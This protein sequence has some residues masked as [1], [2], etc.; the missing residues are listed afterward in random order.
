MTK[1]F[2]KHVVRIAVALVMFF[3]VMMLPIDRWFEAPTNVYVEFAL[4]L[5]PYLVAGYDVLIAAFKN[6]LKG[7]ALDEDFLMTV[8]TIGAFAMVFF[9]DSSPHMAEGAA[10]MLFFQ[11][12]E[13]FQEYAVGKSR[14]SIVHGAVDHVED[15][16]LGHEDH[17]GAVD[18]GK[19][20]DA[21]L[22][23]ASAVGAAEVLELIRLLHGMLLW[24][25]GGWMK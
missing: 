9:P 3:I 6:I 21:L 4:F 12:G 8:A 10:V 17:L 1:K 24:G 19:R 7:N 16:L 14:R 22:H 15:E 11:V 13:L 18:V 20:A 5:V 25:W 23:L 2:K